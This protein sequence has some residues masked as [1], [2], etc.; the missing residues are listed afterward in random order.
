MSSLTLFSSPPF[1]PP[2]SSEYHEALIEARLGV[3]ERCQLV[4]DLYGDQREAV[5][6]RVALYYISREHHRMKDPQYDVRN[7][8]F[9]FR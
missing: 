5:F 2:P 4:A 8:N 6:W 7:D 3:A 1:S 9:V